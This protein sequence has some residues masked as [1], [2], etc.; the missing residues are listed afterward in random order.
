M[1]QGSFQSHMIVH[2]TNTCPYTYGQQSFITSI[3]NYVFEHSFHSDSY[4]TF[5]F[6][7]VAV[8]RKEIQDETDRITGRTKQISPIPIH[9]SIYS[10]NGKN[11]FD[12]QFL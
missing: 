3:E 6:H 9:L 4:L 1:G 12:C 8:V 7:A 2:S 10:P 5:V 11:I